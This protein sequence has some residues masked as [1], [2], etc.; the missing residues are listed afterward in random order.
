MK[1]FNLTR[2]TKTWNLR[3]A[4]WM[5][6]ESHRESVWVVDLSRYNISNVGAAR[7]FR[8]RDEILFPGVNYW[9]LVVMREHFLICAFNI[10]P[11]QIITVDCPIVGLW[12]RV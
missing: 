12:R 9:L 2:E 8:D 7:F 1:M 11:Y 6:S 4:T 3:S 10:F 5:K